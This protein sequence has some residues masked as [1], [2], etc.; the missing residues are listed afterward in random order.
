VTRRYLR[1][2]KLFDF[3]GHNYDTTENAVAEDRSE[4]VHE[5]EDARVKIKQ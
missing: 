5:M 1:V 4:N 3:G 2:V